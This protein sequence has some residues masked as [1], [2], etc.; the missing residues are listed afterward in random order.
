[1]SR[2]SGVKFFPRNLDR[3]TEGREKDKRTEVTCTE[4]AEKSE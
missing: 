3:S 4:E 2:C 1:M